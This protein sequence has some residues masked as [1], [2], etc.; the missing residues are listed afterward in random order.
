MRNV[1][2]ASSCIGPGSGGASAT[3]DP[4]FMS[5]R[6]LNGGTASAKPVGV[7]VNVVWRRVKGRAFTTSLSPTLMIVGT[8]KVCLSETMSTGRRSRSPL[9]G[10][11][12]L[13]LRIRRAR[14]RGEFRRLREIVLTVEIEI[15]RRAD[16]GH[17]AEAS[18]R[19]ARKPSHRCAAPLVAVQPIVAQSNWRLDSELGAD[20]RAVAAGAEAGKSGGQCRQN[21]CFARS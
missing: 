9:A 6:G 18:Q 3:S 13:F 21:C 5:L 4:L 10:I 20:R 12:A 1:I 2:S 16:Q 11:D 19:R 14:R 7:N 17:A 15:E 8:L